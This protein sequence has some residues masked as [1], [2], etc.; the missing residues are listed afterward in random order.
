M[1]RPDAEAAAVAVVSPQPARDVAAAL[2]DAEAAAEEVVV[3]SP[4]PARDVAV[5]LPDV[6]AAVAAAMASPQPGQDGPAQPMA[7][8]A[9]A[10]TA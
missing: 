10:S 3:A 7:A 4:Q 1:V 5:A 6:G 2:P 9:A 8:R